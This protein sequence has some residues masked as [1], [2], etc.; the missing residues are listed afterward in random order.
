MKSMFRDVWN[1]CENI[2]DVVIPD[3]KKNL[4]PSTGCQVS[5]SKPIQ[6]I[7]ENRPCCKSKAF[8]MA[9]QK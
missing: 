9:T 5:F 2:E 7:V 6:L 8:S 4:I 3:E 1:W